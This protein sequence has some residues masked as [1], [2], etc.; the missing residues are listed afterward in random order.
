MAVYVN[1]SIDLAVTAAEI[2]QAVRMIVDGELKGEKG[3]RGDK[4]DTGSKGDTGLQGP[5]GETGADGRSLQI[6]DVYPTLAALNAA[7]PAGTIGAFQVA[8]NGELYIWSETNLAWESIGV[9]EGPEGPKGIQ[10]VQGETGPSG[11]TGK[12][13]PQGP[14]G[15]DGAT[16]PQGI[17]GATGADGAK[18]DTGTQGQTGLTGADGKSAYVAAKE[19]GFEGTEAVFGTSMAALPAHLDDNVRHIT[20]AERTEWNAK[21]TPSGAQDKANAAEQNAKNVSRPSTWTPTAADVGAVKSTS[22]ADIQIVA[23]FPAS[24]VTGVLYLT[25]EA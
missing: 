25:M 3:D 1:K 2:N 24:P 20:A 15:V 5:K 14:A 12:T 13:G 7:F 19:A 8:T 10:G 23:S 4:G 17:Q 21:E 18:G 22:V 11:E 9:L 6:E 16:G